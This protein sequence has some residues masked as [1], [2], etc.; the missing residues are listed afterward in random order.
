MLPQ[1]E[2]LGRVHGRRNFGVQYVERGTATIRSQKIL[3]HGQR[4]FRHV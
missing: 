2:D 3:E 4:R 1:F